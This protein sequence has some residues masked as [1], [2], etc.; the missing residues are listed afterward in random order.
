MICGSCHAPDPQNRIAAQ[1]GWIIS[2]QEFAEM[3]HSAH[4]TASAHYG[5]LTCSTCHDQH[6]STAYA[7]GVKP[8][9]TCSACHPGRVIPGKESLECLDCH[10]PYSVKSALAYNPRRADMRSHQFRIWV[11]TAPKDSMFY[12]DASGTF[13]KL[14]AGGLAVGNTLD[15]ACQRCHPS[16]S[17]ADLFPYADNI[18]E[19][20][21]S[22]GPAPVAVPARYALLGN[23]PNPFNP[24]T[25]L[26]FRLPAPGYVSLRVYDTA[27]RQLST[28][29]EGWREAG[30]HQVMFDG[31]GLASGVYLVVM[32]AGDFRA[33]AKMALIR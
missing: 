16:W 32:E 5:Y 17:L 19:E 4:Y 33:A 9:P 10:M 30:T 31:T 2:G 8:Y 28:L 3:Q 13:V 21:L 26:G 15:L 11:T 6:Q 23:H 20:G 25:A 1:D 24:E 7:Q 29:V 27:G 12:T 18:H 14:D 22:A